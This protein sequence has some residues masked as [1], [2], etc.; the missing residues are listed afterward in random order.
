MVSPFFKYCLAIYMKTKK[1]NSKTKQ[2]NP[3]ERL[4]KIVR[5]DS[6]VVALDR[7]AIIQ[8]GGKQYFALEGKTLAV[9]KLPGGCDDEILFDEVLLRRTNSTTCEI[10]QPFLETPV[11]AVIVKHI[12]GPKIIVFKFKR[13]KK[14][15]TKKGHRQ[16]YTVVRFT[17]IG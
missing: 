9:E 10:G 2:L 3:A 15:R 6:D 16:P 4:E 1:L 13:R 17:S 8:T 11:K 14:Q 12:R 7:Y 5:P